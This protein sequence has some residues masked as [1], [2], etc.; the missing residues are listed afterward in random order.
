MLLLIVML[1]LFAR[2]EA[3]RIARKI[4]NTDADWLDYAQGTWVILRTV[5]QFWLAPVGW[6]WM[7]VKWVVKEVIK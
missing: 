6:L 2:I 4:P 5:L 1:A 7:G 3:L